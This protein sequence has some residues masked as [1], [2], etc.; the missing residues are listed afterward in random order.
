ME[1]VRNANGSSLAEYKQRY[2]SAEKSA[3]E[4]TAELQSVQTVRALV[5]PTFLL[6]HAWLFQ[7]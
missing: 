6:G 4:A 1:S 3:K 5:I 2:L 7:R